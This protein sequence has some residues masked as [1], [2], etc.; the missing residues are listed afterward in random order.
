MWQSERP[1]II[2][3]AKPT[4]SSVSEDFNAVPDAASGDNVSCS[5]APFKKKVVDVPMEQPLRPAVS[6]N[7]FDVVDLSPLI[8]GNSNAEEQ[9]RVAQSL[10]KAFERTGFALVVG[11][12]IDADAIE[13]LRSAATVFFESEPS[14]KA[15]YDKGK[16]YGFGGYCSNRENSAQLLGDFS[17]PNDL[18]ETLI[19]PAR[20]CGSDTGAGCN[21]SD[22]GTLWDSSDVP[23]SMSEPLR[24][25]EKQRVNFSSAISK[26]TMLSLNVSLDELEFLTE[27]RSADTRL[28]YYPRLEGDPLPGQLRYGAHI[29]SG[30]I[31]VLSLDPSNPA[32]LQ[33]D[34]SDVGA[35]G[36]ESSHRWVDVPKGEDPSTIVLNVGALLSRW[37]CGRWRP[38]VHRVLSGNGEP[39]LSVVTSAMVPRD[40]GPAFGGFGVGCAGLEPVRASDFLATRVA[41][42]RPE[43]AEETGLQTQDHF[44]DESR[45]IRDLLK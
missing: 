31:T 42:H 23:P 5:N 17:R 37:T 40:D 14:V 44:E 16:G 38:A 13:A 34:L 27:S 18:V 36:D 33:V 39:R 35:N 15:K 10:S 3:H 26:A 24:R 41:L 20:N 11:H 7:T 4:L 22:E 25:F 21:S 28:A 43:Y 29:D 9:L 32:G 30:T 8:D 45:Q 19:L 1:N 2:L 6:E 12:G